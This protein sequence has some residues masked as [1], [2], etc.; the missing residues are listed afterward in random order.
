MKITRIEAQVK[1]KGRYSV[2]VDEKFAFGISELGLINSGLRI[3]QEISKVDLEKLKEQA[4]TDKIYNQV[5]SLIARRPRSRWEIESYLY[6]KI[7]I[8]KDS[9]WKSK[10]VVEEIINTLSDKGF[11]NDADFARRWVESRRLLKNI[12]QRKLRLELKQ[13]RVVDEI[14]DEVLAADKTDEIEVIKAEINKKRRQTRYQ[15]DQ[16]LIAYLSRQG[17]N[18]GDIKSALAAIK[19]Q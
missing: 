3:G 8:S 6:N 17:Y 15:D 4:K 12:S 19:G 10:D 2:F 5:L 7:P 13:K 18:Y 1:R 11:V 16:K 9:P 14:V